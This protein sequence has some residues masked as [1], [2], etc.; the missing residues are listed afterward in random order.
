MRF[1]NATAANGAISSTLNPGEQI[2]GWYIDSVKLHLS[3][4]GG[5]GNFTVTVDSGLGA[6]YDTVIYTVDLTALTDVM[7]IPTRIIYL[8]NGDKLVF[9]FA[10][11]NNRAYGLEAVWSPSN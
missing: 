9:A 2:K 4:A 3:A 7:W 10:N 11:A 6:T 5:A 8:Q 1:H